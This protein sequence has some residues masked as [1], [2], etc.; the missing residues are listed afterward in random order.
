MDNQY[1]YF[2]NP[3]NEYL[4]LDID[5]KIVYHIRKLVLMPR[6]FRKFPEVKN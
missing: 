3:L 1:Y 2:K 5:L 4:T 6:K